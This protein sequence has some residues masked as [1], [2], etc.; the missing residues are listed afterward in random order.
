MSLR[1]HVRV[2]TDIS[3]NDGFDSFASL[4]LNQTTNVR[5]EA[6]GPY[7]ILYLNNTVD[8]F[9]TLGGVR[10]SGQATLFVSD[11]WHTPASAKI[12]PIQMTPISEI[13]FLQ[14]KAF[15][16]RL[17]KAAAFEE[18]AVVPVNYSLSFDITPSGTTSDWANI[19]HY[20]RSMSDL[21]RMPGN[22]CFKT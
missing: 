22:F 11:P 3:W 17:S 13:E 8:N 1:L 15:N 5:L 12:G 7:I 9:V 21:V 18:T 20:T 19:I 4:P 10:S 14:S 6:A 16:G 2:G